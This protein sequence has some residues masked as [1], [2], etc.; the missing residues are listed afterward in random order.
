MSVFMSVPR[1]KSTYSIPREASESA[2]ELSQRRV[3]LIRSARTLCHTFPS[4]LTNGASDR[5]AYLH[6]LLRQCIDE[7]GLA[8]PKADVARS[9]RLALL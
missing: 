8:F 7:S 2:R 9:H 4:C 6:F 3:E 5:T 1:N